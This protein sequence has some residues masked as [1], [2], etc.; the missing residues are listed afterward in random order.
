MDQILSINNTFVPLGFGFFG[1][2][3]IY[4]FSHLVFYL[5]RPL[6]PVYWNLAIAK[7]LEIV[8]PLSTLKFDNF[9]LNFNKFLPERASSHL[10]LE[11]IKMN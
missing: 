11:K 3:V 9:F 1:L 4:F 7:S 10:F 2:M 8:G 5:F 6:N